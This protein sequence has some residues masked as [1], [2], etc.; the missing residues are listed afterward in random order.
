MDTL[1]IIETPFRGDNEEERENH[2][3]F[4]RACMADSLGRGEAP[5][6]FHMLYPESVGGVLE[7]SSADQRQRGMD[8][9]FQWYS[10]AELLAVYED[11]GISKGMRKGIAQASN[12]DRMSVKFRRLDQSDFAPEWYTDQKYIS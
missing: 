3:R 9:A 5:I 12:Q 11:R 6:L 8:A 1:V 4:A 2:K 10:R 7:D